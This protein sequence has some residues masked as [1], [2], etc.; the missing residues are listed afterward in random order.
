MVSTKRGEFDE[1]GWRDIGA[2]L[3][4]NMV[5]YSLKYELN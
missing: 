4:Q 5:S 2:A 3:V 1:Q